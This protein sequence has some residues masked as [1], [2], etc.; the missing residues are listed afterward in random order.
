MKE[1]K[2][3]SPIDGTRATAHSYFVALDGSRRPR[4]ED[5]ARYLATKI[6][7]FAIPR[8]QVHRALNEAIL[9]NSS[10]P[11]VSLNMKAQSLFTKQPQS[12]EGGEVLLSVL[13]ETFLELPQL[14]TKMVL[15]TSTEMHVHGSDGIHGGITD[16]GHLALYWGE[17]KLYAN[18]GHAM[19]ACL[20]SL[21]PY[22][23]DTGGTNAS[24]RRDLELMRDGLE[25]PSDDLVE[26][27]KCYLDPDHELYNTVQFRGLC[28]IAFDSSSYPEKP[29]QK[30]AS[31]LKQELEQALSTLQG[32]FATRCGTRRIT[33]F[34]MEVFFIPLPDVEAFRTAFR[35]EIFPSYE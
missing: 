6:T 34:D 9:K 23:T 19:G 24:F 13:A 11:I 20:D 15:K 30:T 16:E 8:P 2:I 25:L 32:S 1:V 27:L 35:K 33:D 17:S 28:L 4:V 5:F 14:F 29:N 22:L 10:S 21:A 3:K 26:A 18:V 12:G 31:D 7:D